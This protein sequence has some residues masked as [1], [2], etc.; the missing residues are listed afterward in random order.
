MTRAARVTAPLVVAL[1]LLAGCSGDDEPAGSARDAVAQAPADATEQ[2]YCAAT[3]SLA[4]YVM[5]VTTDRDQ[6]MAGMKKWA[7]EMTDVGTPATFSEEERAGF[8]QTIEL[9]QTLDPQLDGADLAEIEEN[10]PEAEKAAAAAFDEATV[11]LCG[12][13]LENLE[14]PEIPTS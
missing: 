3:D 5:S 14:L 6:L 10:Q 4:D 1:A 7:D 8:E 11:A 12:S 9:I 13:P 2:A